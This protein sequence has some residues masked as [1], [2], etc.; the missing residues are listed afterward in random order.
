[1]KEFTNALIFYLLIGCQNS[2][3][4][5]E[6]NFKSFEL[7]ES[8]KTIVLS[9]SEIGFEEI[10]YIPLE[11]NDLCMI[12]NLHEIRFGEKFF[13]I[14]SSNT[15]LKFNNNGSFST[16]IGI[17]GRGP[18]EYINATDIDIDNDSQ[19]IYLVSTWQK[20]FNVY[21]ESGE[22]IRA[23]HCPQ[24]TTNFRITSDGILCYNM[25]ILGNV[26]L[27][28]NF[29]DLEGREIKSFI[30]KYRW[31]F[32]SKET[33]GIIHEN[34]FYRY[35]NQL[36]KKEVYSDTVYAFEELSF[37]PRYTIAA[38]KHL[39]TPEARSEFSPTYLGENYITPFNMFSFGDYIYYEYAIKRK[40]FSFIGSVRD[41][42]E[43]F[44]NPEQGLF[45]DLD[46]GPNILPK[47][48]KDDNT[49]ISWV[50]AIKL[51]KHVA[52]E[53]FK[54]SRPKYPEK[55]KELEKLANSLKDTD[56]PVLVLVRLKE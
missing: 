26:E 10:E 51:K 46:G 38:G 53:L 42:V 18:F 22:F 14:N 39:I 50:D 13:I 52:S 27:S 24:N 21:S 17:I 2:D 31:D 8:P 40:F 47:T 35:G 6:I 28:Y 1:M 34:L 4:N 12:K 29:I 9:L 30:N 55:K 45:N 3:T 15:I 41:N 25:N 23:F 11:T 33:Y 44:I 19:D 37:K 48:I 20:K 49:I 56:N 16:K 54:N 5:T 7:K 36:F 32:N 43:A